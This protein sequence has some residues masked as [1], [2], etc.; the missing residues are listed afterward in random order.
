MTG[1]D[2]YERLRDEIITG[3]LQPNER[4]VEHERNRGAKVRLVGERE[5]VEILETRAVLEGLIARKAAANA[6]AEDV[7]ELQAILATMRDL[8]DEGNLLGSSVPNVRLHAAILRIADHRTVE[9]VVSTLNSQ[10]VRYQYRTILQ[11]GRPDQSFAEHQAIVDA[12][13]AGDEDAAETAMR[14][15]LSQVAENLRSVVLAG[16]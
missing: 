6:T 14:W 7:S 5:A 16:G 3:R 10:L 4:L 11:P 9:R 8:L 13:A 12:I 2:P 15:H 1:V